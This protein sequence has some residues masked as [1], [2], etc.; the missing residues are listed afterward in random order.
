LL[1]ALA[2]SAYGHVIPL[3]A[4]VAPSAP[5]TQISH[6]PA[7]TVIAH[8]PAHIVHAHVPAAIL[9]APHHL[10]SHHAIVAPAAAIVAPG[11]AVYTGK[12]IIVS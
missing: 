1:L 9:A 4:V 10:V 3:T 2:V 8:S 6:L 7:A 5:I 12:T 11:P